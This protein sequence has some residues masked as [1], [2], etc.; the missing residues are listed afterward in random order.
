MWLDWPL[1]LLWWTELCQQLRDKPISGL[2]GWYDPFEGDDSKWQVHSMNLPDH[3]DHRTLP[4]RSKIVGYD[5]I[6]QL[7]YVEEILMST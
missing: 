6:F 2:Q 4:G 1:A 7:T 5:A 3:H